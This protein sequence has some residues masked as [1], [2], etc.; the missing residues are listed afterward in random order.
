[1]RILRHLVAIGI[2]VGFAYLYV[3]QQKQPARVEIASEEFDPF[4]G[5]DELDGAPAFDA[6]P[7]F[8]AASES[9]S[10]PR[11]SDVPQ[12]IPFSVAGRDDV[13]ADLTN[14]SESVNDDIQ[15][16]LD[17]AHQQATQSLQ[18]S[19]E[20][21]QSLWNEPGQAIKRSPRQ[22]SGS[23]SKSTS[24]NPAADIAKQIPDTIRN[25]VDQ[26][27]NDSPSSKAVIADKNK[28]G[29]SKA[30]ASEEKAQVARPLAYREFTLGVGP[31]A[32]AC[33]IDH[34]V[35][36]DGLLLSTLFTGLRRE[37]TSD[38][39]RNR[40]ER[41]ILFVGQPTS[42]PN[43]A[44]LHQR[45]REAGVSRVVHLVRSNDSRGWLRFSSE[46][47]SINALMSVPGA[48]RI[49]AEPKIARSMTGDDS[50]TTVSIEL[51]REI[52]T[53]EAATVNLVSSALL[54]DWGKR[55]D[56]PYSGQILQSMK[57]Q[58]EKQPEPA[59]VEEIKRPTMTQKNSSTLQAESTE[60]KSNPT[61]QQNEE[62]TTSSFFAE[63]YQGKQSTQ[64]PG[65]N[66]P[67]PKKKPATKPAPKNQTGAAETES[68]LGQAES[69]WNQFV[70]EAEDKSSTIEQKVKKQIAD[71][72]DQVPPPVDLLPDPTELSKVNSGALQS[73][74]AESQVVD[75]LPP[76]PAFTPRPDVTSIDQNAF[77]KLPPPPPG[78]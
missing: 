29:N 67:T 69:L 21:V 48:Y 31:E 49:E 20:G 18:Q 9:E 50:I 57:P 71:V 22:Q 5:W 10:T 25:A 45:L 11:R 44:E 54:E 8:N 19:K 36:Q 27:N 2:I 7:A 30:A 1:M 63:L 58:P 23:G 59:K 76:P 64:P 17:G 12:P 34:S 40:E 74:L 16:Q 70:G 38:L 53:Q 41:L 52:S 51:P 47:E 56:L 24:Q 28:A 32:T 46:Q 13:I 72:V 42:N 4:S 77:F 15:K 78:K 35:S 33:V 6:A 60:S 39:E 61:P 3:Q 55:P 37:W 68:L 66:A 14:W 43:S 62:E 73:Q 26:L 65:Q 75:M